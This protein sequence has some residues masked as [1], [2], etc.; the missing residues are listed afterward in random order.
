MAF[1][2]IGPGKWPYA[3]G[4]DNPFDPDLQL[5]FARRVSML[6]G[7]G[8]GYAATQADLDQMVTDGDVFDGLLM[9]CAADDSMRKY[10]SGSWLRHA[11]ADG[12]GTIATLVAVNG[13]TSQV[14]TFPAGRFTQVPRIFC[15]SESGRL[16]LAVTA[17]STSGFTMTV[18]NW[19]NADNAAGTLFWWYAIQNWS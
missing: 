13:A 8:V 6:A 15:G 17:R 7:A 9:Y 1:Q 2:T 12:S 16:N 18:N 4:T 5:A 14:V 10:V 11:E 19:S 3:A